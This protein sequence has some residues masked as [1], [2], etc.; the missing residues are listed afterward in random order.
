MTK[1]IHYP[2]IIRAL[3][4]QTI[5]VG[6]WLPI[7]VLV[8]LL[9]VIVVIA[10]RGTQKSARK[11]LMRSRT[12]TRSLSDRNEELKRN[13]AEMQARNAADLAQTRAILDEA[14]ASGSQVVRETREGVVQATREETQRAKA[15]IIKAREEHLAELRRE[16]ASIGQD[17]PPAGS[18]NSTGSTGQGQ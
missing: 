6:A 13:L 1:A 2:V 4:G 18:S 15:D 17:E 12:P 11:S 7:V 3:T 5:A 14:R 10:Y 9:L 16:G 8:V